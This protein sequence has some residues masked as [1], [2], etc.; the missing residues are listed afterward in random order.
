MGNS[1]NK[2]QA[3]RE[4]ES[5]RARK[6][7]VCREMLIQWVPGVFQQGRRAQTHD[8]EIWPHQPPT[9]DTHVF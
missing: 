8:D 1:T 9:A 3:G 5:P 2:Q 4:G 7:G 6:Q